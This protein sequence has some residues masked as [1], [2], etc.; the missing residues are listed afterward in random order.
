MNE[1]FRALPEHVQKKILGKA[2]GGVMQRPLF[3]QMGGPA[4]P[5]PQ[6]MMQNAQQEGQVLGEEIASRTQQSIDQATDVEGAINALRGNDKPLEARYQELAGFVGERDAMQTPESVLALTQPTI[7]MSEQGAMDSGIGELMQSVAGDTNM[8]QGMDQGLGALMMQGAGNTP[9]ENFNQGGPVEVRKFQ[10]GTPKDG[11]SSAPTTMIDRVPS[12]YEGLLPL[13]QGIFGTEEERQ[14]ELEKDRQMARS[15]LMFDLAGAGLA[16]AG[17]TEGGSVA[18]RLANALNRTQLTDRF[19][20]RASQVR[21]AEKEMEA[22]DRQARST[23]LTLAVPEASAQQRAMESLIEAKAKLKPEKPDEVVLYTIDENKLPIVYGVYNKN[24]PVSFAK[25]QADATLAD[26]F[27]KE[28]VSPYITAA[29]TAARLQEEIKVYGQDAKFYEVQTTQRLKIGGKPVTIQAGTIVNLNNKQR[30]EYI[31][32]G[33]SLAPMPANPS[34]RIFYRKDNTDTIQINENSALGKAWIE[35]NAGEGGTYTASSAGYDKQFDEPTTEL[36]FRKVTPKDGSKPYFERKEVLTSSVSDKKIF[37]DLINT[38]ASEDDVA[39]YSGWSTDTT[40]VDAYLAEEKSIAALFREREGQ[41]Q[42]V[43]LDR[44]ITLPSGLFFKKGPQLV[45]TNQ[46]IAL[47][48]KARGAINT[49]VLSEKDIFQKTGFFRDELTELRNKDEN[50]YKAMMGAPVLTD[51][52]FLLKYNLTMD[53]FY[54]LPKDEQM[55]RAGMVPKITMVNLA[56]PKTG[57]TVTLNANEANAR[58]VINGL[59]Q[60]G[61]VETGTF[62]KESAEK[63]T[64]YVTTKQIQVGQQT[65]PANTFVELT[66]QQV[67]DLEDPTAVRSQLTGSA[68]TLLKTKD[69]VPQIVNFMGGNFYDVEGK[70]INFNSPEYEGAI[71]LGENN[72]F[73]S[74]KNARRAAETQDKLAQ[75]NSELYV[76]LHGSE[77]YKNLEEKLGEEGVKE[78]FGDLSGPNLLARTVDIAAEARNGVGP[79]AKLRKFAND[80]TSFTPG[81]WGLQNMFIDTITAQAWIDALNVSVRIALAATPRLSEGEQMRLGRAIPSTDR[82][83]Q[84][85]EAAIAD[86][87]VLRK[88]LLIERDK[89]L[90]TIGISTNENSIKRA[91]DQNFAIQTFLDLMHQLPDEGYV[92]TRL[93]DEANDRIGAKE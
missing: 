16:F 40:L 1:G 32:S 91:Q 13:T 67:L 27:D 93:I 38:G 52:D 18:E 30:E 72:V 2:G 65:I 10:A 59:L 9:P 66:N 56:N 71:I 33:V 80:L 31:N 83:L 81:S 62:D 46:L 70:P 87:I 78:M 34:F 54:A 8:D 7:M 17:E 21:A 14:A 19:A 84:T 15:Q 37:R 51:K 89:N 86:Y 36:V 55:L 75:I 35:K 53:E 50:L 5:M 61:Y 48:Q 68:K 26:V 47:Q 74:V 58:T 39:K 63:T 85:P 22:L 4:Q 45:N 76:K 11:N 29:E 44:D 6:E 23:A 82:F 24:D 28:A 92:D 57:E 77:A 12:I 42:M 3:R 79:Y 73:T 88:R 25:F 49:D 43:D 90:R 60:E 64:G 69:G 41:M 20:Q